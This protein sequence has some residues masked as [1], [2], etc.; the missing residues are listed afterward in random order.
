MRSSAWKPDATQKEKIVAFTDVL[1]LK[2][3]KQ[4]QKKLA[5][6]IGEAGQEELVVAQFWKTVSSEKLGVWFRDQARQHFPRVTSAML[7]SY[8]S[9]K[10]FNKTGQHVF[11]RLLTSHPSSAL[12]GACSY[13]SWDIATIQKGLGLPVDSNLDVPENLNGMGSLL[14]P[15]EGML[16]KEIMRCTSLLQ[17]AAEK[18][19]TYYHNIFTQYVVMALYAATGARP[20]RDPFESLVGFSFEHKAVY[21]N[22]KSNPGGGRLVP[23]AEN[24][25]ILLLA[26]VEHLRKLIEATA[27][28]RPDLAELLLKLTEG[29][30]DPDIPL[31][32]LLDE[33][34]RWHSM[35][36]ADHLEC[37]LF[38]WGLP[39]N[40][41]RHRFSQQ[42]LLTEVHPE[43]IDAWMGHGE[44]GV[45]TYS[46]YSPRCWID[47]AIAYQPALNPPYS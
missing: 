23:L 33:H 10:I 28:H 8:Q 13:A 34:L 18:G 6:V 1:S 4:I 20:L 3:P 21:I 35:A 44:R 30:P 39:A 47:D 9:Q 12:P 11:S 36:D 45:A 38:D 2:V 17:Q 37:A 29:E 5:Q 40:L 43:V 25:V 16:K 31:F 32:F 41:F 15:L 14:A 27:N 24:V 19:L 22:D 7:A 42:L 46:D 26:Y